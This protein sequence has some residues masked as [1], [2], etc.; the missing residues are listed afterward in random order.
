MKWIQLNWTELN[1][2]KQ[3]WFDLKRTKLIISCK[4]DLIGLDWIDLM[5]EPKKFNRNLEVRRLL[6]NDDCQYYALI[7]EHSS[8]ASV[9]LC[10]KYGFY[11]P[12]RIKPLVF[13]IGVTQA[14]P[15]G[16]LV[17]L[18]DV[19]IPYCQVSQIGNRKCRVMTISNYLRDEL[20]ISIYLPLVFPISDV[21]N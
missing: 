3:N 6:Q 11:Y 4:Q 14:P 13:M 8:V 7:N 20:L 15:W 1:Q 12:T 18:S 21:G 10:K 9:A 5:A 19:S 17:L 16:N 2:A